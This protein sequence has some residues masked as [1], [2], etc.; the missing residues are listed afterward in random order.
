MALLHFSTGKG[1]LL[2]TESWKSCRNPLADH[3]SISVDAYWGKL[4][5][6]WSICSTQIRE[7]LLVEIIQS[8]TQFSQLQN[9]CLLVTANSSLC[10]H[11]TVALSESTQ[12][13]H[14]HSLS[15]VVASSLGHFQGAARDSPEENG[16]FVYLLFQNKPPCNPASAC[17]PQRND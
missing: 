3:L 15:S 5:F 17:P 8:K 6:L 4:V 9:I 12:Q 7:V 2:H 16:V 13:T 10:S 1:N 14:G 11:P